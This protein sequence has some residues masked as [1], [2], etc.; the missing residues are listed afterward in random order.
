MSKHIILYIAGCPHHTIVYNYVIN[1][2]AT[3]ELHQ[4]VSPNNIQSQKIYNCLLDF[5]DGVYGCTYND[6]RSIACVLLCLFVISIYWL[7]KINQPLPLIQQ[8]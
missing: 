4:E 8:T 3:H 1:G 5:A 7:A 6:K 2:N